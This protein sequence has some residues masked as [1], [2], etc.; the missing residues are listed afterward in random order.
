MS[1]TKSYNQIIF[2]TTLSVY[3]GLVLVGASPQ[4]LAQAALTNK[5]ELK[6]Q[7]EQKD[8]LDKKPEGNPNLRE[9][10]IDEAISVLLKELNEFENENPTYFKVEG[11]F[12]KRRE[13]DFEFGN[14][15]QINNSVVSRNQKLDLIF[16]NFF[17]AIDSEQLRHLADFTKKGSSKKTSKSLLFEVYPTLES[18]LK[19]LISFE[20]D[21][22]EKATYLENLLNIEFAFRANKAKTYLSKKIYENTKAVSQSNQVFIVTRLP[23]GSIDSLLK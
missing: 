1:K 17:D 10:R 23:R 3:L 13:L 15:P 16:K 9:V 18:S 2:I 22:T 21:S 4:V 5:F 19:L 20:K 8:D 12:Y 6:D 14:L 11:D 7:I